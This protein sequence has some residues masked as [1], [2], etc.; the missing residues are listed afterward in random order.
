MRSLGVCLALMLSATAGFAEKVPLP[1]LSA[2]LNDLKTLKAEFVQL[3]EDGTTST[4][5]LYI[6]RP[7]KMRFEY[8][9]P[10]EGLV[11]V[12][13]QTVAIFDKKSNQRAETYPLRRTPLSIILA[14]NVDLS[15]AKMVTSHD[16]DGTATIVTAQDPDRPEI[17]N[18][19]L[20][21]T[22]NPVE[23]RQWVTTDSSGGQTTVILGAVD[24]AAQMPNRLFSIE[25]ADNDR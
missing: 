17:G 19:Q 20:K 18:I 25:R 8:N 22:G 3:N 14:R 11:V 7:G 24:R 9:P 1:A 21:F 6:K 16:F 4:G 13:A 23:L 2:Y 12:E 10:D 5:L 15:R